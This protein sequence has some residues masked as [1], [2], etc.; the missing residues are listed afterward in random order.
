MILPQNEVVEPFT[1]QEVVPH[2]VPQEEPHSQTQQPQIQE[3]PV[4][5]RRSTREKRNA[6]SSD[7]IVYLNEQ[8]INDD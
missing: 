6:I 5:L 2:L 7:Y 1:H 4:A 8:E 3:E